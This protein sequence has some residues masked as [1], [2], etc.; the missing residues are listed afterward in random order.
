MLGHSEKNADGTQIPEYRFEVGEVLDRISDDP[1]GQILSMT[2]RVERDQFALDV[3]KSQSCRLSVQREGG[4][5]AGETLE[6]QEECLHLR[7]SAA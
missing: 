5:S 4:V 7:S 1:G 2:T 6:P 3:G